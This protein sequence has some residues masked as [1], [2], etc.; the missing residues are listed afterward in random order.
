[1]VVVDFGIDDIR[2]QA[3]RRREGGEIVA[4]TCS[5][6]GVPGRACVGNF[7]NLHRCCQRPPTDDHAFL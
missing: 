7:G 3:R 1:L 6:E 2:P 5:A 4:A